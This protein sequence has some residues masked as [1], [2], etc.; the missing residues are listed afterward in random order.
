LGGVP[1]HGIA[2]GRRVGIP[3]LALEAGLVAGGVHGLQR[4]GV[5][6]DPRGRSGLA[7]PGAVTVALVPELGPHLGVVGQV[8][9]L[10]FRGG[11]GGGEGLALDRRLVAG[12]ALQSGGVGTHQALVV[13]V[14]VGVVVDPPG[15]AALVVTEA[16]PTHVAPRGGVG[17]DVG[18]EV[19]GQLAPRPEGGLASLVAIGRTGVGLLGDGV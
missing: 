16:E 17:A 10:A 11:P 4:V 19:V 3:G 8:P 15:L 6:E 12:D 7:V 2:V 13:V 18:G 1:A 14:G 9:D 5:A